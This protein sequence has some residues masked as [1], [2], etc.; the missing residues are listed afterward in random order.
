MSNIRDIFGR[1][2]IGHNISLIARDPSAVDQRRPRQ[3]VAAAQ[4]LQVPGSKADKMR[5]LV[6]NDLMGHWRSPNASFVEI[7]SAIRILM[8]RTD[9]HR[10]FLPSGGFPAWHRHFAAKHT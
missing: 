4:T 3:E 8:S 2:R 6:P 9:L 10:I 1:R 5:T 7:A